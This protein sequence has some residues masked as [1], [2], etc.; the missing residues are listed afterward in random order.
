MSG[1]KSWRRKSALSAGDRGREEGRLEQ[2][3]SCRGGGE[4]QG[5]NLKESREE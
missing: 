5:L 1:E 3:V 2:M 4:T